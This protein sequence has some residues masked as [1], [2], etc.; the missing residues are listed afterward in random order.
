MEY[1]YKAEVTINEDKAL[2]DGVK[3]A[4]LYAAIDDCF[5]EDKIYKEVNDKLITYYTNDKEK[6]GMISACVLSLYDSP[7]R[8]YLASL[9]WYNK[10]LDNVEDVLEVLKSE[11]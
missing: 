2:S 9:V 11:K 1:V 5:K 4:G 6:N 10:L 7:M 3:L 8:P